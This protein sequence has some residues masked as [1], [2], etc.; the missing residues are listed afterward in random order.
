MTFYRYYY[1]MG[2]HLLD[3]FKHCISFESLKFHLKLRLLKNL[4]K[5][6]ITSFY[7]ASKIIFEHFLSNL[8]FRTFSFEQYLLSLFLRFLCHPFL[9][10]N[11]KK[12]WRRFLFLFL[13]KGK[14]FPGTKTCQKLIE[15]LDIFTIV[16]YLLML[17]LLAQQLAKIGLSF[18]R[19]HLKIIIFD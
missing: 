10:P 4:S 13:K 9:Q 8:F 18:L 2:P 1:F 17:D 14:K 5:S 19:K 3:P 15:K 6:L 7:F 12:R 11:N 16:N